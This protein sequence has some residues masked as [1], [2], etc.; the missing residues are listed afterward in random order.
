MA[1]RLDHGLDLATLAAAYAAGLRPSE[2]VDAVLQAIEA[3]GEDHVWI[4]GALADHARAAARRLEGLDR[5]AL[6]LYGVPF[7]I[8]DNIDVA[9]LT[10][11]AACPGFAHVAKTTAP[12]VAALEEAGA[13]LV[14]KTNLDQFATGL[15]GCRSP[16]GIPANAL[17][18]AMIPGGS[19]SGS[20]VA[21]AAGLVGF[22]LGTDTAGS[23]RVPAMLNNLVGL[24]PTRGLLGTRGVVPACR[25]LD[26]VSI[27]ALN[28]ADAGAVLAVAEGFDPADPFSRRRGPG[29]AA[30]R[31][32]GVP[33]AG[34]LDFDGDDAAAGLFAA[35]VDRA[36]ALGATLVEIDLT[37]FVE[38]AKLLY[39]GPWVAERTAALRTMLANAPDA[40]HPVTR[41]IVMGGLE[42]TAVEAFE[43]AYRLAEL[44]RA[45]EPVWDDV[46]A[47]L[48]PTAPTAYTIEAMLADPIGLNSRLGHYTNFVN[49]FDLA[50]IAVPAGFLES[51][52]GFGV[53]LVAPAWSE[54]ALLAAGDTLH[55]AAGTG[56]GAAKR[57]LPEAKPPAP[58]RFPLVV[59]GAHMQD[60]PLN[61]QLTERGAVFVETTRTAPDYRLY[62][63]PGAPAR[64]GL[65]RTAANDGAAI[66]VEV[67]DLPVEA[68]GSLL[69][70]VPAPLGFAPVRLADGR[71][72]HG[73]VCEA[74]AVG[75]ARD[76]T[77][78]GGWRAHLAATG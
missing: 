20:A 18:P 71:L 29:I 46:D 49:L 59:C 28:A 67:W 40:L 14:G 68:I 55:R 26:C 63:L 65:V 32:L 60:L 78:L 62:A 35:A 64:P 27:F 48:L 24:K 1:W 13:I 23:G 61:V 42:R 50:A 56:M 58:E 77:H 21:V 43:G 53:T 8:K 66:E 34:D 9:G 12:V 47:L 54:P 30:I 31:R 70:L 76:I 44:R 69:A 52:V 75:D 11:T 25:S 37:P 73:F 33:R 22:A 2:V 6:P 17:A 10:T 51:G 4:G 41:R 19:S 38:A 3:R 7:A 45:T 16:Y 39:D 5:T 57:V 72:R 15:S 36:R 74:A